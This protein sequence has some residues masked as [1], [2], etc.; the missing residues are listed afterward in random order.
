MHCFKFT[1]DKHWSDTQVP[2]KHGNVFFGG[3]LP[4]GNHK[5]HTATWISDA[6]TILSMGAHPATH[7][8]SKCIQSLQNWLLYS[9][10]PHRITSCKNGVHSAKLCCVKSCLAGWRA[11]CSP[12][13]L[14]MMQTNYRTHARSTK[15]ANGLSY[16]GWHVCSSL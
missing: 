1:T 13:C 16:D 6:P 10:R 9:T 14:T 4:P 3:S 15:G 5:D 7:I 2:S 8:H 12:E 11:P